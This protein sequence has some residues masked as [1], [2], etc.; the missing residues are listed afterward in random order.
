MAMFS[1]YDG[2][3]SFW[4]WDLGQRLV[5]S[6]EICCEVHFC[7]RTTKNA[8]ICEVYSQDGQ[9]LV[10]VPNI[11]LQTGKP[12]RVFACT[13]DETIHSEVFAV[14]ARTKPAD[15]VYTETEVKTYEALESR[16]ADL[17]AGGGGTGGG[18][19][20]K[21]GITPHIGANG[22]WYIGETDTGMQSRGEKGDP[23]EPGKDGQPG[24]DG[25]DGQDG[26]TPQKGVDYY[27]EADKTEMVNAVLSALPTWEGGSY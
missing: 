21:D 11:L 9:R 24:A 25:K 22:N 6:D 27:T 3:T 26:Y 8:L 16:I 20:G 14:I 7:N 19:S 15:Y 4:Q 12:L 18:T 2:R 5:V 13:Q 17:E 1:I 10:D 23:G